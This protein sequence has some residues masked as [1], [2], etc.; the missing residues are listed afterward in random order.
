[1][2]MKFA[3]A[4]LALLVG[5]ISG[6]AHAQQQDQLSWS[7]KSSLSSF[8]TS[9]STYSHSVSP[10]AKMYLSSATRDANTEEDFKEIMVAS[11]ILYCQKVLEDLTYSTPN[12]AQVKSNFELELKNDLTSL[13]DA[14]E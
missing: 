10:L 8:V 5:S 14:T 12:Y 11:R 9:N 2:K 3:L 1:M 6:I 13:K 4:T 7:V